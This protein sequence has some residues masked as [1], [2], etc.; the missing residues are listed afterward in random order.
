MLFG[1][2]QFSNIFI[3]DAILPPYKGSTFRGGFGHALKHVTC[4]RTNPSCETCMLVKQ[5]VYVKLFEPKLLKKYLPD[6]K[7]MSTIPTPFV[8]EPP[9]N[10]DTNFFPHDA[11]IFHLLL[12]G[13]ANQ[14]L[15]YFIYAFDQMGKKGIGKYID[16]Q[17][18]QFKLQAVK[19]RDTLL[20]E[21]GKMITDSIVDIETLTI[22]HTL[23]N[24]HHISA[25]KL[26]IDTPLRFKINRKLS[27]E[28]TFEQL[29]RVMLRR[30]SFLLATYGSG[31]P[32]LDYS[33][34]IER[35]KS[36]RTTT[37]HLKWHSWR[38]YSS[39]QDR[40]MDMGG[41]L[42]SIIY[43]GKLDEFMPLIHFCSKVHIGKQT[44]FGL[45]NIR[46]EIIN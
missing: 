16:H 39:R 7:Q 35:A 19:C 33:G 27:N 37:N 13:E 4:A 8:I 36:V 3:N 23:E 24:T 26:M 29:T 12:F 18:G 32:H 22:N 28:L 25:I 10:P 44:T 30:I 38:R 2:Y 17:H 6:V 9:S 15:P 34:I 46:C 45:G 20:Y 40:D 42:G 14:Y 21:N 43:E 41:L 11:F 31:N 5:C 1:K